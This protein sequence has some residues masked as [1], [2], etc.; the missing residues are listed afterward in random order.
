MK[1]FQLTKW[2]HDAELRDVPQPD[3]KPGE[4]LVRI[5]AA[6]ACHSDLHLMHDFVDGMVD[7]E[8]PFTIGHENAGWVEAIGDGV[9][10]LEVGEPVAVYGPWGCGRC[11]SCLTG[12]ENYCERQAT[13]AGSGGGLGF[14]GGMAS[15]MIVPNSRWLV[16]LGDLDPVL[17]APLTDAGLTPYHAVKRSLPLLVP[18]S[19]ALVIGAGGLGHLAI[20]ILRALSPATVVVVDQRDEALEHARH[21][22]AHEVVHAGDGAA[23]QITDITKGRGIDVAID[24]VGVDDDAQ[25]RIPGHPPARPHHARR[26]R[27]RKAVGAVLL[28]R[29]RGLGGQHVL[30]HAARA[31]RGARAGPQRAHPAEVQ[32]FGLDD[33]ARA[34]SDLNDGKVAGRAVIVPNG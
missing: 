11:H 17:A 8:L 24:L 21:V 25:A 28:P 12:A 14:D 32:R 22:G 9:R 27:R 19:F 34:Y 10:G 31:R 2:G 1:A 6:G 23:A 16:S 4:V 18:G 33:A 30:G 20:Q 29:L 13:L 3:P 7:Y 5:A 15:H 26:C